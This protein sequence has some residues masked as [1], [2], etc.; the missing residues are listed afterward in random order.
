MAFR[1]YMGVR[2]GPPGKASRFYQ[3]GRDADNVVS[4][5]LQG[6]LKVLPENSLRLV[7]SFGVVAEMRVSSVSGRRVILGPFS[8]L[9]ASL[10]P[11]QLIVSYSTRTSNSLN[12]SVISPR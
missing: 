6:S 10:P 4:I 1:C 11:S 7:P 2:L 9:S 8:R 3:R 5:S 12:R